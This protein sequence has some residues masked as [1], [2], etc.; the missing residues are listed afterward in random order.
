MAIE[1]DGTLVAVWVDN[2][3]ELW[4]ARSSG[5]G[6]QVTPRAVNPALNNQ[7]TRDFAVVAGTT[8]PWVT[9]TDWS[10]D[11]YLSQLNR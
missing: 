1:P 6:W 5:T 10:D 11:L 9:F 4:V 3:Y 2:E 8:G 7:W